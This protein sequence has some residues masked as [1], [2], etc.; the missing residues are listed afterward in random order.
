MIH[1]QP[2]PN[3]APWYH[4]QARASGKACLT[5]TELS[6]LYSYVRVPR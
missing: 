3:K 6:N 4:G 1:K 5:V 2:N